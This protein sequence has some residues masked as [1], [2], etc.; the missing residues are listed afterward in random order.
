MGLPEVGEGGRKTSLV[1]P[2]E[3]RVTAL[4]GGI[5]SEPCFLSLLSVT[6]LTKAT[7][8]GDGLSGVFRCSFFFFFFLWEHNDTGIKSKQNGSRRIPLWGCPRRFLPSLLYSFNPL[9]QRDAAALESQFYS[10][11]KGLDG[12]PPHPL[13]AAGGAGASPSIRWMWSGSL[14]K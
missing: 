3:D 12:C 10:H 2:G 6:P 8:S 4:V 11:V 1:A 9:Q 13:L 7:G 5:N 14:S